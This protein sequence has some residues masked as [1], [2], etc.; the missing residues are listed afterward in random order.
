MV[1]SHPSGPCILV[2]PRHVELPYTVAMICERKTPSGHVVATNSL[3]MPM[4]IKAA[5]VAGYYFGFEAKGVVVLRL[6]ANLSD[7]RF[8][9]FVQILTLLFGK[10]V[11]RGGHALGIL[12]LT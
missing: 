8:L 1:S 9:C 3:P 12:P 10:L 4:K 7:N 6:P 5:P 11:R 2:L